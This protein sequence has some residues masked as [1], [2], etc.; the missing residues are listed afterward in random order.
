MDRQV[1]RI[2]AML[3]N[4][5]VNDHSAALMREVWN[6][7]EGWTVVMTVGTM[8]VGGSQ[9]GGRCRTSKRPALQKRYGSGEV[10]PATKLLITGNEHQNIQS[11]PGR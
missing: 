8:N 3:S 5:F 1:F 7:V 9:V 11:R 2:V 6:A 4:R 10:G